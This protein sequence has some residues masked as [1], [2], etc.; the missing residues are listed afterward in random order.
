VA[1]DAIRIWRRNKALLS[2]ATAPLEKRSNSQAD[3]IQKHFRADLLEP[4]EKEN[5]D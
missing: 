4:I 1:N 2:F 5:S 3:R